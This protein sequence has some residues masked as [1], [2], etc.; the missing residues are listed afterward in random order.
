MPAYQTLDPTVVGTWIYQQLSANAVLTGR[1][2]DRMWSA[3]GVPATSD[4]DF[5]FPYLFWRVQPGGDLGLV[6]HYVT[7]GAI[8][9]RLATTYSVRSVDR[10]QGPFS[11]KDFSATVEA[12]IEALVGVRQTAVVRDSVQI[13][14]IDQSRFMG[15]DGHDGDVS[16][17]VRTPE[18]GIIIEVIWRGVPTIETP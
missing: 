18:R 15:F 9:G 13:G 7:K 4:P 12:L 14:T 17:D 1:H 3:E 10:Y 5:M 16:G 8:V 2:G 6:Q 11:N